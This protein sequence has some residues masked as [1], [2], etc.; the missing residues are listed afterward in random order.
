MA[1]NDQE[2]G[3]NGEISKYIFFRENIST[4]EDEIAEKIHIL[5][6]RLDKKWEQNRR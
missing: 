6:K 4:D 5:D 2:N 1:E 3:K